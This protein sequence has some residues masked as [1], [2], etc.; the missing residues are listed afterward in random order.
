MK[1]VDARNLVR[2]FG[3][4]NALCGV[5]F[6]AGAGER[7]AIVGRNGAGKTTLLRILAGLI[8]ADSGAAAVAGFD[9]FSESLSVRERVGYLPE[10]VALDPDLTVAGYLKYRGKLR[11]MPRRHLRRRFHE[12]TEFFDLARILRFPVKALSAGRRHAVGLADCLLHEPEVLLLDDPLAGLDPRQGARLGAM[13]SSP[14]VSAGR[15]ILFATHDENLVRAAA[16]RVLVLERGRLIGD[17]PG[18]SPGMTLP[19][20]FEACLRASDADVGGKS[21]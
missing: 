11:G 16:T 2:R 14:R 5:S 19:G 18:L 9:V 6:A 7:I 20:A 8:P 1:I 21:K 17:L 3:R 4:E 13:I 15:A 12:V 10:G